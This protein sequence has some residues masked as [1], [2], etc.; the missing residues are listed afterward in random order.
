M[1]SSTVARRRPSKDEPF[2]L[3]PASGD[4]TASYLSGAAAFKNLLLTILSSGDYRCAGNVHSAALGLSATGRPQTFDPEHLPA[5]RPTSPISRNH[6]NREE[7]RMQPIA[8]CRTLQ[9]QPLC[10]ARR[11]CC[12]LLA[13]FCVAILTLLIPASG[14]E[15][16]A[17]ISGQVADPSGAV[18]PGAVITAVNDKTNVKAT[19]KSDGHGVYSFP[20][21][22]AGTYTVTVT[23]P[24]FQTK[25]YKNQVLDSE[26]KLGLNVTLPLGNVSEQVVVSANDVALDTVSATQGGVID[27]TR[28]ENMPSAGQEVYDDVAFADGVRLE[29]NGFNTTP[30]NNTVGYTVGGAQTNANAFY[31]NGAPVSDQGGWHFV[32]SQQ[33]VAQV[34]ALAQPY[35]AQYGRTQGGAFTAIVKNGT[36]ALHGSVYDFYGNEALNANTWI[37]DLNHNPKTV[38]IRDTFGAEVGGPIIRNKT[39]FFGSFEAFRQDQPLPTT[40]TVPTAAEIAGNFQGTGYTIYDPLST[41]CAKKN[42]SG[43]CTTYARTPFLN[44]MIPMNRISP[45]G[46]AI[47]A[48]YPAPTTSGLTN[49]FYAAGPLHVAYTQYIGRIDQNFT[50]NTKLYVLF[51]YQNNHYSTSGNGF[52]GDANTDFLQTN[53]DYNGIIDLTHVFSSKIVLDAKAYYGYNNGFSTYG[54]AVQDNFTASKLGFNQPAVPTTP[55]QNIVPSLSI[56]NETGLFDNRGN[57]SEDI[58]ADFQV[59]A[60]QLVGRHNLHYGGEFLDIQQAPTGVLGT[61]N[62]SFSFGANFTQGNPLTAVTGQ[63]NSIADVLLGYPTS[64]SVVWQTPTFITQ[65]YY[66][67]F[68]QDDF[69]V[70][71]NLSLNLGLRWDVNTSPRDRHNRI[72][73][74]FCL[75]C[76]N[77][78]SSQVNFASAPDLQSPL[79][80][81]L[82][83]AGV[84]GAPSSPY[85]VQWNDYQPRVGFSWAVAPDTVIRGGYGIY[86]PWGTI[87]TD[88]I[89]FS[90]TTNFTA[91]LDGNLTPDNYLNSGTPYPSGALAPTGASAGLTT[92]AGNAVSYN[93]TQRRLRVVQHWSI[94]IQQRLPGAIIFDLEYVGSNDQHLPVTSNLGVISNAQQAAC[95][96]DLSLC[97]TNVPNPFYGVLASNT[98]LGAS[99][100]IPRWELLRAYPL[101][102]GLSEQRLPIGSS[103]YNALDVRL[104]RRVKSLNFVLNYAWSNW[105]DR[106]TYLN[107]GRFQDSQL[108]TTLDDGDVRNYTAL[109]VVYPLPSTRKN[110]IVGALANGWLVDSA[111]IVSTGNP[112]NLPTADFSCGSLYPA[113]GQ[114]RAHWF[115]NDES[116]WHPLGT[117]ERQTTSHSVGF[118]R[119]PRLVLWNP[120]FYKQF[121]LPYREMAVRFRVEAYN[122]ANHPTFGSPSTNVSLA[123][124]YTPGTSYTGLGTLPTSQNDSPRVILTSLK[125]IF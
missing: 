45:I 116:C 4:G 44:D 2:D 123:P 61:P 64:G 57:G 109:N 25:V 10:R 90:Q 95:N 30:R 77:P 11:R 20:Y 115:N 83:F 86:Y 56:G 78:I 36:N 19:A 28:V 34:V 58:N 24:H 118:I 7:I 122:G 104:E 14:Q 48:A 5:A 40:Q 82:Q 42:T 63:G 98:G 117:W 71:R 51:T 111:I 67:A 87:S 91:S 74:G 22:L 38:N 23:S 50:E 66:G 76:T 112:L 62:G 18:I 46:Q 29:G 49:N 9:T 43:G 47:L 79:L 80:G 26:Q 96:V 37:S 100:T 73:D 65:H 13:I 121:K 59:S 35:D 88:N 107:S 3:S 93:D 52:P 17:S 6:G 8:L 53:D 94:G 114:T 102:N 33:A 97:N 31:L 70:L 105:I 54:T 60:T 110:G 119:D 55:H 81:G 103:H 101:F 32:P 89:G 16:R 125:I 21:L 120:A 27:Q 69:Q 85:K 108:N 15:F 12:G 113:G 84:N 99:P 124:S 106:D 1:R 41:Y 39:F 72:N 68:L 75:T 92:N